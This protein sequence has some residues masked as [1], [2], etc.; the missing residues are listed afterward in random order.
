LTQQQ[1]G[2][3]VP[4]RDHQLR[5]VGQR[6]AKFAREPKVGDLELAAVGE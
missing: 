1:L 4:Q 6:I 2:R 3:P 5:H